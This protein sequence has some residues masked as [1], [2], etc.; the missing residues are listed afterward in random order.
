[1]TLSFI[2]PLRTWKALF[3]GLLCILV[4]AGFT[5]DSR[6]PRPFHGTYQTTTTIVDPTPPDQEIMVQGTGTATHLGRST[7]DSYS[8][9]D[10]PTNQFHGTATLTAAND[11][12]LHM[13]FYGSTTYPGDGT[14]FIERHYTITGGTGRFAG[15]SGS[16]ASYSTGTAGNPPG[17]VSNFNRISFEGAISY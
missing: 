12:E 7:L 6:H 15:A 16:L 1:M 13:T 2:A 14:V 17:S 8:Y 11:D 5:N 10:R 9:I 3:A 4:S